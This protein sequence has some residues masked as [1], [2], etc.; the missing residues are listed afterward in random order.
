M[1]D[2]RPRPAD[3]ARDCQVEGEEQNETGV[4]MVGVDVV[5]DVD[6]ADLTWI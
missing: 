5:D 3:R 4:L 1:G 2:R 6:T